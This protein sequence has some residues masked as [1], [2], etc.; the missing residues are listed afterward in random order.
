MGQ[1]E[2]GNA[3]GA[4][5]V[6]ENIQMRENKS[7]IWAKTER[8]ERSSPLEFGE[9]ASQVEGTAAHCPHPTSWHR[10]NCEAGAD[11]A[12]LWAGR[13]E[14]R[15]GLDH[16]GPGDHLGIWLPLQVEWKT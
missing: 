9:R 16:A 8:G 15:V 13:G 7:G 14:V 10:D 3:R 1:N 12:G 6:E 2:A 5:A 11:G 4:A